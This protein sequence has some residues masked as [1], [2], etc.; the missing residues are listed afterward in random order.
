MKKQIS[1][2][3]QVM[4]RNIILVL[5]PPLCPLLGVPIQNNHGDRQ[6]KLYTMTQ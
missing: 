4:L 1:D 6:F 3:L 5:K 2:E